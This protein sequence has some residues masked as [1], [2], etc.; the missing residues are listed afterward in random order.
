MYRPPLSFSSGFNLFNSVSVIYIVYI[1]N[2]SLHDKT[3]KLVEVGS[4]PV[5]Y[6]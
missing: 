5:L 4:P 6:F 3:S 1:E 2:K